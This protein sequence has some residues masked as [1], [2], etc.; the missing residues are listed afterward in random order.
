[1]AKVIYK[2]FLSR[3]HGSLH[4]DWMGNWNFKCL[5][6]IQQR[7]VC[8]HIKF[9]KLHYGINHNT[10]K[11]LKCTSFLVE[12]HLGIKCIGP[13]TMIKYMEIFH[14]QCPLTLPLKWKI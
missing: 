12:M 10:P 9:T 5:M 1:M 8:C 3:N 11:W 2:M 14:F 7:G 4:Y 13:R 6:K